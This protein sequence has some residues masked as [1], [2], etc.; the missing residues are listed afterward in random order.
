[1]SADQITLIVAVFILAG[2]V[3]GLC[4]RNGRRVAGSYHSR[5]LA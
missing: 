1:M 4:T 3:V 2:T 5:G